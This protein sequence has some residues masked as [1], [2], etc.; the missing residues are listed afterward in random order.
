MNSVPQLR[1]YI[2]SLTP[3]ICQ[4]TTNG[5]GDAIV[6]NFNPRVSIPTIGRIQAHIQSW[7]IFKV[8]YVSGWDSYAHTRMRCLHCIHI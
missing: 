8:P 4:L 6:I 7:N 1:A 5:A 3:N 2:D